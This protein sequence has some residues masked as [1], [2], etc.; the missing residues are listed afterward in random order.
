M[1]EIENGQRSESPIFEM[2]K[3]YFVKGRK[4]AKYIIKRNPGA[5]YYKELS[6][7]TQKYGYRFVLT[8]DI[9][10]DIAYWATQIVK[11]PLVKPIL[12]LVDETGRLKPEYEEYY[13]GMDRN[14]ET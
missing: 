12:N 11:K 1:E 3:T 5:V 9:I 2:P 4:L 8:K 6:Y 10:E 7:S 13:S 14:A